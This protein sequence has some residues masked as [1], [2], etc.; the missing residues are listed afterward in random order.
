MDLPVKLEGQWI[1]HTLQN[2]II[3]KQQKWKEVRERKMMWE[4]ASV[5]IGT[6]KVIFI[7]DH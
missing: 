4:Q 6:T 5:K 7:L 1:Q 2:A 3:M